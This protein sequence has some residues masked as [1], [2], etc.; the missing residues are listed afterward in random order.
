MTS[1][2]VLKLLLGL[3][4]GLPLLQAVFVWV[5]GLLAAM[6]D[7]ATADVLGYVN[8]AT[9]VTWLASLVGLVV[10]LAVHSLEEPRDLDL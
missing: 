8:T 2:A 6:G 9:R 7:T 5:A 1:R 4:L 10:L 3:V